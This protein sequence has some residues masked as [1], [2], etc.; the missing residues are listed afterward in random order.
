MRS[1]LIYLITN[2]VNGKRYIGQT[3]RTLRQ[4]WQQHVRDAK[5][6][7]DTLL[8]NAIRKYGAESFTIEVVAESY[9]PFLNDVEKLAIWTYQSHREHDGYNLTRGGDGVGSGEDHPNYGKRGVLCPHFGI[10]RTLEQRAKLS[11][12]KTGKPNLAGRGKPC[13]AA[14]RAAISAANT[15]RKQ[16]QEQVDNRTAALRG[17]KRPGTLSQYRHITWIKDR[18]KW[19]AQLNVNGKN[20]YIGK[21]REEIEAA[22]AVDSYIIEHGLSNTLNF[23]V[24]ELLVSC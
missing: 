18:N 21:Y 5:Q 11:A 22:Q 20:V 2:T 6:G 3:V 12:A 1:G 7:V 17:K 8:Y 13:S 15:G 10:K 9:A 19:M 23:P 16:S 24:S 14:R 4:R